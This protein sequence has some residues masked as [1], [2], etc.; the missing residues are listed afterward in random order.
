MQAADFFVDEGAVE[1]LC[2]TPSGRLFPATPPSRLVHVEGTTAA[3]RCSTYAVGH[4][5]ILE[6]GVKGEAEL[7]CPRARHIQCEPCNLC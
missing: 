6:A 3:G 2:S 5:H 7:V 1:V 4:P